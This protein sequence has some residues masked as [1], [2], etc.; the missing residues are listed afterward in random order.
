MGDY[1]LASLPVVTHNSLS[2]R[3]TLLASHKT[4]EV[5][6]QNIR[7]KEIMSSQCTVAFPD[8]DLFT[9]LKRFAASDVGNLPVVTRENPDCPVGLVTR[10]ALWQAIE[11]ARERRGRERE[12]KDG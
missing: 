5:Q 7:V 4:P 12:G 3:I 10:S 9:I 11:S 2:G 1:G 6:R 8:E